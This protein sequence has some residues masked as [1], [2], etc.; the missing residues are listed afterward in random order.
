MWQAEHGFEVAVD[1]LNDVYHYFNLRVIIRF[2]VENNKLFNNLTE[3]VASGIHIVG[4]VCRPPEAGQRFDGSAVA[5]GGSMVARNMRSTM[6]AAA[7]RAAPRR[8]WPSRLATQ[9]LVELTISSLGPCAID[10]VLTPYN[11]FIF[12]R[13]PF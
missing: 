2:P 13:R 1:S 10:S 5:V 7:A 8:G 9:S 12:G 6:R 11:L 3:P 4:R